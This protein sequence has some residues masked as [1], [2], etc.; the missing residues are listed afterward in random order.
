MI[1]NLRLVSVVLRVH[2]PA[3]LEDVEQEGDEDNDSNETARA[4]ATLRV[5]FKW[6]VM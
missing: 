2:L 6:S 1:R 5:L 4:K 3:L